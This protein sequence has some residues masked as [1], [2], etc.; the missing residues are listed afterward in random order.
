MTWNGIYRNIGVSTLFFVP[1]YL[2][3]VLFPVKTVHP[4]TV[5]ELLKKTFCTFSGFVKFF[6]VLRSALTKWNYLLISIFAIML[7]LVSCVPFVVARVRVG[8]V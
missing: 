4:R 7:V 1:I 2:E 3:P 8:L 5:A 6:K